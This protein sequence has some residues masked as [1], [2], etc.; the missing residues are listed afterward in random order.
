MGGPESIRRGA[1]EVPGDRRNIC[2]KTSFALSCSKVPELKSPWEHTRSSLRSLI[3]RS[4]EDKKIPF[5]KMNEK[6]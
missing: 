2:A 3:N 1:I 5:R 4:E 6:Y